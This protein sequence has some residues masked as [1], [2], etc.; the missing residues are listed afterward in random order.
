MVTLEE[1]PWIKNIK[2]V[3][4]EELVG[5]QI[6]PNHPIF[7]LVWINRE[8]LSGSPCFYGSRT[9]IK[10]LFDYLESGYSV[11]EFLK[12]FD[13]VTREQVTGVLEVA[14]LGLLAELPKA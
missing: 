9:P 2:P 3:L 4:P 14:R 7:G 6:S 8:R 13:G 12:D 1:R 5:D 10:S 11:D